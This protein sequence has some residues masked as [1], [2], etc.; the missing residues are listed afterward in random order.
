MLESMEEKEDSPVVN[1]SVMPNL[2]TEI[3]SAVQDKQPPL[4]QFEAVPA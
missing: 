1:I 4:E 2:H 3:P